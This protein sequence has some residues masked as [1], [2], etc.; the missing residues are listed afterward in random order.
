MN[1]QRANQQLRAQWPDLSKD[2]KAIE[3]AK[4][5]MGWKD[6]TTEQQMDASRYMLKLAQE[7]KES[8]K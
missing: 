6:M 8:L 3:L 5:A 2:E 7:F 1:K 4:S